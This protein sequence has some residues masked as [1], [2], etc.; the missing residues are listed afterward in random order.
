MNVSKNGHVAG[1]VNEGGLLFADDDELKTIYNILKIHG[2][3]VLEPGTGDGDLEKYI[4]IGPETIGLLAKTLE[5]FGYDVDTNSDSEPTYPRDH[6]AGMRVPKGGSSCASCK[7]VSDDGKDCSNIHFRVW[8]G[9]SHLPAPADEYCSDWYEPKKDIAAAGSHEGALKGWDTRGRSIHESNDLVRRWKGGDKASS[10]EGGPPFKLQTGLNYKN[11]T[12]PNLKEPPF[13]ELPPGMHAAAGII[14][15]E[16][17]GRV[18]T[19]TPMNYY[20]GYVQTFPKGTLQGMESLQQAAIREVHEETG[21]VPKITGFAGDVTRTTSVTRYYFGERVGGS[22]EGADKETFKVN[23]IPA[24]EHL[25]NRLLNVDNEKTSDHTLIQQ[26]KTDPSK[27]DPI[28]T[29]TGEAQGTNKGGFYKGSDG[30]DR[31]VKFYK[32]SVQGKGEVLANE[33]Y[34]DLGVGAPKSAIF[35]TPQGEAF[36]SE[37]IK[38][39]K[40]LN[41]VPLTSALATKIMDGFAADVLTANWDAVGLEHDNVR[42]TSNGTPYRV[43]NGGSFLMRAQ[44]GRKPDALLN[45]PTETKGFFDPKINKMYLTVAKAA[46]YTSVESMGH[47]LESQVSKISALESKSGGWDKY[48]TDKIPSLTGSD[49]DK[50]VGMLNARTAALKS[51]AGI[52]AA[53][54]PGVEHPTGEGS[55]VSAPVEEGVFDKDK[56]WHGVDLD[57][58]IA[59]HKAWKGPTHV[60]RPINGDA[61]KQVKEWLKHGEKVKI[62]SARASHPESIKPIEDWCLK[63]FGQKLEITDRKD[64]NMIDALD[65]RIFHIKENT[66]KI[67]GATETSGQATLWNGIKLVN[68]TGPQEEA[69]RAMLSR[70]PP[71]LLVHVLCVESA[72]ELNAKHGRYLSDEHKILFNPGNLILR[73]RFGKGEL[74]IL[75]ADLTLV[76]EVGHSLYKAL[77]P[78]E[79]LAWLRI[80][81]WYPGSKAGQAPAYVEKRPGWEHNI[82]RWTH[83][84]GAKFSRYYGEKNPDE[85]FADCFAFYLMNKAHEIGDEKK[86][87]FDAYIQQHVKRY[88]QASIQSPIKAGGVN[89]NKRA[90]SSV[91]TQGKQIHIQQGDGADTRGSEHSPAKLQRDGFKPRLPQR[92]SSQELQAEGNREG[93]LKGWDTR[94]RGRHMKPRPDDPK[95]EH[96]KSKFEEKEL[97]VKPPVP[98]VPKQTTPT[99]FNYGYKDPNPPYVSPKDP[100]KDPDTGKKKY[101]PGEK[102]LEKFQKYQSGDVP[103]KGGKTA[104]LGGI[105]TGNAAPVVVYKAMMTGEWHTKAD[106]LAKMPPDVVAKWNKQSAADPKAWTP[107]ERVESGIR[108]VEKA[109]KQFGQWTM[110]SKWENGQQ[111]FHLNMTLVQDQAKGQVGVTKELQHDALTVIQKM[112]SNT[113]LDTTVSKQ[114][115]ADYLKEVGLKDVD[116]LAG[117]VSSWTGDPDGERAQYLKRIA[118]D[119]YGNDWSKE[120]KDGN[121]NT[122]ANDPAQFKYADLQ[123]QAMAIKALSN[124]YMKASGITYL[125]RGMSLSTDKMAEIKAAKAAGKDVPIPLNSA[126]GFSKSYS[127]ASGSFGHSF[128]IRIKVNP[129]D[130]WV[131]SG[132]LPHMFGHY[133]KGEKEYIVGSKSNTVTYIPAE[134]VY[135]KSGSYG[136]ELSKPSWVK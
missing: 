33:I 105:W 37:L 44:Q 78:Q 81:G 87:F 117:S 69:I 132:A 93:A 115:M 36:G 3:K 92:T 55:S 125:Y 27:F 133:A 86:A 103:S 102:Q 136:E 66:G 1:W 8:N 14:M 123:K 83:K 51:L 106:L 12:D 46:G 64:E 9:S 76:H 113:G 108:R 131:A 30:V 56:G 34:R 99:P 53:S 43:D 98:S 13:P 6:K 58:T 15:Q 60:G 75:H 128:V 18:W 38:G 52:K 121:Q 88:P 118:A 129:E 74:P 21:L 94:G 57:G 91:L 135:I 114:A 82:S 77:T 22:P 24:D 19:V 32:D 40:E 35:D 41:S 71:E 72:P 122:K 89:G 111:Y 61:L 4:P 26:F 31:Y 96:Y 127:T 17:D 45:N 84:V 120:W 28:E 10:A 23:L 67:L 65:D 20:G 62:F 112:V 119:Y 39:S 116:L 85:D 5:G 7:Y 48:V 50:I 2:I 100:Y 97:G 11:L 68:F 126:T 25:A 59:Y 70:I 95:A 130:V 79:Q 109:G 49:R 29:K 16:K 73:Q 90:H 101:K 80:S 63:V 110:E 104:I 124:E 42:V 47:E 107:T 54:D 134:D